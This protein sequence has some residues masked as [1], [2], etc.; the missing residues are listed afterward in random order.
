MVQDDS[1]P[2]GTVVYTDCGVFIRT[3]YSQAQINSGINDTAKDAWYNGLI[4]QAK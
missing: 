2:K 4:H 3:G 1:A